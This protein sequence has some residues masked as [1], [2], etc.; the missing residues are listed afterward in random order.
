MMDSYYFPLLEQYNE[1]KELDGS[2]AIAEGKQRW[3]LDG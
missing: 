2:M 3:S 1:D